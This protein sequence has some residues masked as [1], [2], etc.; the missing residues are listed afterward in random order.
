MKNY[1]S[2]VIALF[3]VLF[4]VSSMMAQENQAENYNTLFYFK[5]IKNADGT[6]VLEVDF[7]ARNKEDRKDKI[8]VTAA[9]IEFLNVLGDDELSLG[10]AN[11]N[12]NGIATLT[13]AA[14]QNYMVDEEGY[15]NLIARFEGTDAMDEEEE[16]LMIKDLLLNMELSIE[17]S[18]KMA[19]ITAVT[20]D[21]TGTEVPVEEMD[22]IVGIESMLSTMPLAED[23]LEEGAFEIEI[24]DDIPGDQN[25]DLIVQAKVDESDEFGTVYAEQKIN[26][27]TRH[28]VIEKKKN[29]LWTKGAPTWMYIILTIML[30]GVWANYVYTVVN[31]RKIKKMGKK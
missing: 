14:E 31:L 27:G 5:T 23:Y 22:I 12:K 11:T 20:L 17:D 18:V 15:I 3:L 26:W 9:P 28:N 16:E 10:K 24:P 8:A 13:L 1:I 2:I 25:G 21:S 29:E 6:R 19:Y 30:G 4:C 7:Q